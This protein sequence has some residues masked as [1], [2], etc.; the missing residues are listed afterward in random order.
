MKCSGTKPAISWR[1]PCT[2]LFFLDPECHLIL[3]TNPYSLRHL[4]CFHDCTYFSLIIFKQKISHI[5]YWTHLLVQRH[6]KKREREN[7][8]PNKTYPTAQIVV[9]FSAWYGKTDA[10][11]LDNSIN[12]HEILKTQLGSSPVSPLGVIPDSLTRFHLNPLQNGTILFL[13]VSWPEITGS[14]KSCEKMQQEMESNPLFFSYSSDCNLWLSFV[15]LLFVCFSCE[16]SFKKKK[17]IKW[18]SS[19]ISFFFNSVYLLPVFSY[20]VSWPYL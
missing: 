4:T 6:K 19:G 1:Y 8:S 11:N 17:S 13:F 2:V 16:G 12:T 3:L 10:S 20:S 15:I 5:C 9:M 14:W 18:Y 7:P